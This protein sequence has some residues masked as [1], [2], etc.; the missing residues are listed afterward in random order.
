M[1]NYRGVCQP[2]HV[3]PWICT[4][5][6]QNWCQ[7]QFFK[8][9]QFLCSHLIRVI[10]HWRIHSFELLSRASLK[11]SQGQIF[12]EKVKLL[13]FLQSKRGPAQVLVREKGRSLTKSNGK[14]MWAW[15]VRA[16]PMV[17]TTTCTRKT[18]PFF[19]N[20]DWIKECRPQN[21]DL[22]KRA[23]WRVHLLHHLADTLVRSC[24]SN[25]QKC[26]GNK[27]HLSPE[28]WTCTWPFRSLEMFSRQFN[29]AL[30]SCKGV[31]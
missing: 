15:K 8:A 24:H 21:S 19:G 14:D 26:K 13:L 30:Y 11:L 25:Y 27:I 18:T 23:A 31:L 9:Q 1:T 5:P 29:N 22:W 7:A 6:T 28:P 4:Q 20:F 10:L 12:W 3:G 2:L 16:K 17:I